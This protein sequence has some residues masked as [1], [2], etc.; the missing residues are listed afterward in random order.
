MTISSEFVYPGS[1]RIKP[2]DRILNGEF[3]IHKI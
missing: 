1:I 2:V 3:E